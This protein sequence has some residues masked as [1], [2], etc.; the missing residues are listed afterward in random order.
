MLIAVYCGP[1]WGVVA[2]A[3]GVAG[4]VF[5]RV[6]GSALCDTGVKDAACVTGSVVIALSGFSK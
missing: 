3:P 6:P 5:M 2:G 1:D 4:V